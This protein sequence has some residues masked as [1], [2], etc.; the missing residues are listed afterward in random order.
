MSGETLGA[1]EKISVAEALR[2]ITLGAA[3]TLK[4]DSEIGSI[5]PGKCADFAVLGADPTQVAPG[6]LKD[7]PVLGTVSGGHVFLL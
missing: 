6:E 1:A 5:T 4:L 3:Y 2:L 7:V